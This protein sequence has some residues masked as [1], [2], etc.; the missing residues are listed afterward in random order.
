M[1]ANN[2]CLL[3]GRNCINCNTLSNGLKFHKDCYNEEL[4]SI[5]TLT[6]SIN[7]IKGKIYRKQSLLSETQNFGHKLKSFFGGSKIDAKKI[8]SQILNFENEIN[9]LKIA[10]DDKKNQLQKLYDYWL[11]IPPD[12]NLRRGIVKQKAFNQCTRCGEE[13]AEKHVHH[14][15]PISKGGNHRIDNLEYLCANCHSEAHHGRDVS[16]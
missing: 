3:C 5:F 14:K 13:H 9:E 7:A 11:E 8:E 2:S 4:D 16:I 6:S 12:W 10:V 1:S 15:I